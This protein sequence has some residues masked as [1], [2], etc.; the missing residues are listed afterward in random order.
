MNNITFPSSDPDLSSNPL[1]VA[2]PLLSV[3]PMQGEIFLM[4]DCPCLP[5]WI[6][7]VSH[8][9]EDAP[10]GFLVSHGTEVV[11]QSAQTPEGEQLLHAWYKEQLTK[12][13]AET[14][15]LPAEYWYG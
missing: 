6:A 4:D 9:H 7:G 2:G 15:D 3:F 5:V 14:S 10:P 8:Q 12:I 11:Y 13:S 1:S